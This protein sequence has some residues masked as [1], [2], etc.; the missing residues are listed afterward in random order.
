VRENRGGSQNF[1]ASGDQVSN[2]LS[3]HAATSR[4]AGHVGAAKGQGRVVD[5]MSRVLQK[6]WA[7]LNLSYAPSVVLSQP[8]GPPPCASD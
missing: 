1:F 2:G 4:L 3:L 6:K 5:H 7:L 8:K